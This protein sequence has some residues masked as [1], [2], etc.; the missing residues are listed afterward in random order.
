[1]DLAW[2]FVQKFPI[3]HIYGSLGAFD[4]RHARHETK[5]YS[6]LVQER[7]S[8]IQLMYEER[9]ENHALH[10]FEKLVEGAYRVVFLALDSILTTL[11][12]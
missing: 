10:A 4:P 11:R 8:T 5:R 12:P 9:G 6:S 3:V 1:M 2:S 7:T